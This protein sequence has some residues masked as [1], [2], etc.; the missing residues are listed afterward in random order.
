MTNGE[1]FQ[2]ALR[3]TFAYS[4]DS[5]RLVA[6]RALAMRV[7]SDPVDGHQGQAGYWAELRGFTGTTIYRRI[8]HDLILSYREV[9][10]SRRGVPT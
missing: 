10:L 2:D 9:Y 1:P 4:D 8:I 7:P 6:S 3:L 5:I